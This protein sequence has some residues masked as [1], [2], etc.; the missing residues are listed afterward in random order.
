MVSS[1][2]SRSA[3]IAE[4]RRIVAAL[5][6]VLVARRALLPVPAG[7]VHH[8][9]GRQQREPLN[10]HG[11]VRQIGNRAVSVLKVEGAEKLF[12]LL[13]VQLRQRLFHR[14][15]GTG[16]LGHG[17]GL[18]LRLRAMDAIHLRFSGVRLGG[19]SAGGG[20]GHSF[21]FDAKLDRLPNHALR[22]AIGSEK[23]SANRRDRW[24]PEQRST[25]LGYAL[26]EANRWSPS[27]RPNSSL[28]A[29]CSTRSSIGP[30]CRRTAH[31]LFSQSWNDL[32]F[33]HFAVD[34]PTLRRLV[35][36]A[37]TLDLYDGVA[38]LTV[39][40]CCA[41]HVRPSG[42]PPLP[43]LSFFPQV[44]L[45]TYVTMEDKPGQSK[46]GLFYFSVDAANLSA[47][48]FARI[49]FRMPYWHAAIQISGATIHARNPAEHHSLSLLS[50][51]WPRRKQ[52]SRQVRRHL[53]SRKRSRA[54]APWKPG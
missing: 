12:R 43:G 20:N 42:V 21:D 45:R 28:R 17:I 50:S 13:L 6:E 38:W 37:L 52:R 15:R 27:S 46:P 48:W 53:L 41:S 32:L 25:E 33:A 26:A 16:V 10:R 30:G 3:A 7:F 19:R 11:D 47:V 8:Q 18:N 5:P 4:S 23:A 51:A 54:G 40:P 9:R 22:S 35:P 49:F 39:S 1:Y 2:S 31:W 34:P 24:N 29:A 44:N 14:Q 36:E